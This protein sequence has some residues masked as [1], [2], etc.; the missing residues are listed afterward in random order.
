MRHR[1]QPNGQRTACLALC[2]ALCAVVI[3]SFLPAGIAA[4]AMPSAT[5]LLGPGALASPEIDG[6]AYVLYDVRS[7]TFLLGENPDRPLAP[8][9]IT[10]VMTALLA[11]ENL[12]LTDTITVTRAMFETIPNDYTRLGLVEGEVIT[13]EETL[14]A[15][16]LISANDAA[17]AL[18]VAVSGSVD[19]F[20]TQMNER[21]AELGC[22]DTHFTNPYGLA[23][24]AHLTT[25]HDM[26][27][28]TAAALEHD[29]FRE[30]TTTRQHMF[31]PTNLYPEARG[32]PNGNRFVSQSAYAYEPYIGGK[33]G[34]TR[35]SGYTIV[36][37]AQQDERTL[38]AVILN[39]SNS[40]V[41]YTDL[42]QLFDYGFSAYLSEAVQEKDYET[43]K[44][45]TRRAIADAIEQAGCKLTL[46]RVT[47]ELTDWVITTP[48]RSAAG[49]TSG[50]DLEAF[51]L[52]KDTADKEV[53]LPL[54]RRYAD[55]S[56]TA[57]GQILLTLRVVE[58]SPTVTET[59]ATT[60]ITQA[61]VPATDDEDSD[62]WRYLL[63]VVL[64]LVC[65]VCLLLLVAMLRR[66]MKRK[67]RKRPRIL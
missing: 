59:T 29:L 67:R 7:E 30:I 15:C 13:V 46:D 16:L 37:G 3:L 17:M 38:V 21:A 55:G 64:G 62:V 32:L 58:P 61:P 5:P 50:V 23:D 45:E 18:A 11:L 54:Y 40:P 4:Q 9:S 12:A 31:P 20:A 63:A 43:V 2:V 66:D 1:L 52:D 27:L 36:A 10:K 19:A 60:A 48:E 53:C 57:T 26:A 49:Y 39:A 25:A 41:R 56:R 44:N 6:E 14:Y 51:D 65:L 47:L 8:A 35:L 34:Y 42:A 33:T 22:T 28:I 24:E